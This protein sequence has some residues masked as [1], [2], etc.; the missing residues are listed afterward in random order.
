[1]RNSPWERISW[2]LFWQREHHFMRLSLA[3]SHDNILLL[4][5][6]DFALRVATK[7][8]LWFM[9]D[10]LTHDSDIVTMAKIATN[11]PLA[12][13]RCLSGISVGLESC[14]LH[15]RLKMALYFSVYT[16]IQ[17]YLLQRQR[18]GQP[19]CSATTYTPSYRWITRTQLPQS[20]IAVLFFSSAG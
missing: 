11:K 19:D 6:W 17:Y 8:R 12:Q 14:H 16:T 5:R 15:E 13:L 9:S 10:N 1:M 4:L 20:V 7:T 2:K 18:R 3:S